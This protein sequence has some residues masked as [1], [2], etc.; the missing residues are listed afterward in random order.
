[1][2]T[3]ECAARP[4]PCW[5]DIPAPQQAYGLIAST[6]QY[7][8]LTVARTTASITRKLMGD[9]VGGGTALP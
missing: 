7:L 2:S 9:Y 5:V 4:R 1:M 6:L 3:Q 8:G